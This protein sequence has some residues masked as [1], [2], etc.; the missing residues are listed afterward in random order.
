MTN[1]QQ[2]TSPRLFVMEISVCYFCSLFIV[3]TLFLYLIFYKDEHGAY[4]SALSQYQI[5]LEALLPILSGETTLVDIIVKW[6]KV[7]YTDG[8]HRAT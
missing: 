3:S 1:T 6:S 2:L 7:L 8:T 5:A 4:E